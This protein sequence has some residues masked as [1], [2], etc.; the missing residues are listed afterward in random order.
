MEKWKIG[1]IVLLL[2]GF[3]GFA[4]THNKP[5]IASP[6]ATPAADANATADQPVLSDPQVAP[7]IG[8]APPAWN[9]PANLWA[10]TKKPLTSADLQ[11]KVTLLEFFRIGC[12][13]CEEAVPFIEAMQK[14]YG[15]HG[16]QIIT[17]Q[18]PGVLTDKSNPELNWSNVKTW[19]K[20][21][22]ATYP[23][24]FDTNRVLK[25]KTGIQTYPLSLVVGRD[26]KIVYGQT[27]HTTKKAQALANKIESVMRNS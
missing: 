9:I 7:L 26:G 21:H 25:N 5:P 13:H 2:A 15:P 12:P 14:E 18:S 4:A 6:Q 22:S 3:A 8:T 20:E 17:F 19:L 24:A 16:L 11:G 10:N 23:A 1:V 27:G